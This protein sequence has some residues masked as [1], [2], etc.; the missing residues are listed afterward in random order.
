MQR[1]RRLEDC[2]ERVRN[3]SKSSERKHAPRLALVGDF[4]ERREELLAVLILDRSIEVGAELSSGVDCSVSH[5]RVRVLH[6]SED[7]A[8]REE[9]LAQV[10]RREGRTALHDELELLDDL[11][12]AAFGDGSDRRE[13]RMSLLP[14]LGSEKR[15]DVLHKG[16]EDD[17]ACRVR[18]AVSVTWSSSRP[19]ESLRKPVQSSLCDN[20]HAVVVVVVKVL[21]AKPVGVFLAFGH[22]GEE[23]GDELVGEVGKALGHRR[24]GLCNTEKEPAEKRS[25]IWVR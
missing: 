14:V 16:R 25:A 6:R 18:S 23:D 22:D 5:A 1:P 4:H 17:L 11:L 2:E 8:A 13:R 12:D 15:V 20:S 19:T 24:C 10:R 7:E 9:K 3:R 21:R